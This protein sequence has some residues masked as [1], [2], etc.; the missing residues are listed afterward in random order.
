MFPQE[1]PGIIQHSLEWDGYSL[2]FVTNYVNIRLGLSGWSRFML[3]VITNIAPFCFQKH[4]G[5]DTNSIVNVIMRK[6]TLPH[7]KTHP[8]QSHLLF[9]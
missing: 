4:P 6:P 9:I 3:N 5:L 2:W 8:V 1:R 7:I